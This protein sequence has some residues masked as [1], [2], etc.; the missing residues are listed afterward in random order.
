[1]SGSPVLFV[2]TDDELSNQLT[3]AIRDAGSTIQLELVRYLHDAVKRFAERSYRAALCVVETPDEIAGVIRLKKAKPDM[4]VVMLT[5]LADPAVSALGEQ[6]GADLVLI[7]R[8]NS[9]RNAQGVLEALETVRL[10]RETRQHVARS[11]E[12]AGDIRELTRGSRELIATAIALAAAS[13]GGEF[14]V[15]VVEDLPTDLILLT[16]ALKNAGLPPFVRAVTTA[17][18]AERYLRGEGGHRNR[19]KSPLPSLIISDLNL[20]GMSGL[21]LLRLVREDPDLRSLGF[22]MYTG[23]DREEDRQE[24]ARLGANFYITKAHDPLPLIEV[25]QSIFARFMQ[26]R[27][28]IPPR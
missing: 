24:A 11:K 10:A 27:A 5:G 13:E 21:G 12:L 22:I 8:G 26:E 25:V 7:R 14:G 9:K 19:A 4:P 1:M 15:L 18:E 23:S 16:R 6:M 28:G 2:T 3:E 20:P 17:E